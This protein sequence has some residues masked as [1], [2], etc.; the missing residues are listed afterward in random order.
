MVSST[1]YGIEA[2]L[3]QIYSILDSFGYEVWISDLGTIPNWFVN[4]PFDDC[5]EAVKSCDLFFSIITP[6]YG[7]G[8]VAGQLGIT[9]Q[10][11][12]MAIK[13]KIPRWVMAHERV[14]LARS[15]FK[16]LGKHSIQ[17]RS[18][19]L[20]SLGLL[21]PD[22]HKKMVRRE[23]KVIEDFR[24]VDMY[25]IAT[26][27]ATASVMSRTGS[28]VQRYRTEED[29]R[30]YVGAQFSDYQRIEGNLAALKQARKKDAKNKATKKAGRH[31]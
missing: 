13:Q 3:E 31:K 22:E 2:T 10:E 9:H 8:V 4:H 24:L 19:L 7:S 11:L 14:I 15:F 6:R 5:L 29:I 26:R 17:Q 23:E 18:D 27:Q 12:E 28:W 20:D 16:K 30:R 1:V 21:A 25:D